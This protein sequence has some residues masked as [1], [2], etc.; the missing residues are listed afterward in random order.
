MTDGKEAT[1]CAALI[2]TQDA[3]TWSA[4]TKTA[5]GYSAV[6]YGGYV[7]TIRAHPEKGRI[8]RND[9]LFRVGDAK[10]L[11]LH[12]RASGSHSISDV[13]RRGGALF[14]ATPK[15]VLFFNGKT[16]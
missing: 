1:Q 8:R 2:Q 13:D 15:R 16:T 10:G 5:P 6:R 3:A 9:L 14:L 12:A 4:A 11:K 7:M